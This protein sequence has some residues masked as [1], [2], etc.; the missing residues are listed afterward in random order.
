MV[1]YNGCVSCGAK[2]VETNVLC[3]K[4]AT[5]TDSRLSL[6]S[7]PTAGEP[8]GPICG[9]EVNDLLWNVNNVVIEHSD[10]L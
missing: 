10:C 5:S 2:L 1:K 6:A 8:N 3:N 9:V 7:K 4:C